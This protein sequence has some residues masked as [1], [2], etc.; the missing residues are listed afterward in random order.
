MIT[1]RSLLKPWAILAAAIGLALLALAACPGLAGADGIVIVDPPPDRPN[2]TWR[3][4]PLSIK[5]HQV[6]VTIKDQVA[7]TRVDQVF[8]ND[9]PFQVEGTYIFPLPEDAAISSFDMTVDGVKYEGQL[10]GREQAREIYEG[11]VR[12]QRD[13]ALLEYVGR[14]AFQARIF[15]IPPG[16]ERRIELS[17]SQVLKLD[18][19]LVHYRYPLNTEKYSAKPIGLVAVTVEIEDQSPIRTVY[20]P[21]HPVEV[22]HETERRATAS[23]EEKDVRPDRDFDLYYSLSTDAISVNLLSY[24]QAS[25]DGYF[26]L[27]VTPP[28]EAPAEAVAKDVVL[29]LDTSGSMDGDKIEQAQAAASF[30]LDNLGPQDRFNIINF[31]TFTHAFADAP[32]P[33]ER[34]EEGKAFVRDLLPEGSTNI[35]GALLE[36]L[37]G[38][39]PE[40]PTIL[41]F[42]TDGKPTANETDPERIVAN[43]SG[44]APKSV[45]LFAFGV[46]FDV[47]TLLLDELSSRTRG[48]SAYVHPHEAI[49]RAMADFYARVSAPVLVDVTMTTEGATLSDLY[50]HPLPDLFAGTQLMIA[51]RYRDG[52]DVRLV[53]AGNVNGQERRYTYSGLSLASRGGNENIARVWAQRKV[54]HLLSLIR[55]EGANPE[56]V[57]QVVDLSTRFG[58]MTPYTSFLVQ[59]PP[60]AQAAQPQVVRPAAEPTM[61][62]EAF[63]APAAAPTSAPAATAAPAAAP[64]RVVTQVV[65]KSVEKIVVVQTQVVEKAVQQWSAPEREGEAAVARVEAEQDL[66]QKAYAAG[67][68]AEGEVRQVGSKAFVQRGGAWVDTTYDAAKMS[69]ERIPFGEGRYFKLIDERPDIGPYL[70][71][72]QRV[73]VVLEGKAYAIGFGE[74]ESAPQPAAQTTPAVQATPTPGGAKGGGSPVCPGAA[75]AA[76]LVLLQVALPVARRVRGK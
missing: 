67:S 8:V 45:R 73:V 55:L 62:P 63:A 20:S 43:V 34:R 22:Q 6:D 59:E 70:A 76:M 11:I 41:I 17:Y 57:Q 60:A 16:A 51:G 47:D 69:I 48:V 3:D 39:D 15:P 75:G 32:Q 65:E 7:T 40:R 42:L 33:L 24:K 74:S 44:K 66:A 25:E 12:K 52:P 35:N 13:P 53:I 10:L 28:M 21:S 72:G 29:V 58:I 71:L 54:G 2:L 1:W 61:A 37:A 4:V 64:E 30:V 14:G 18:Q 49:D 31:G 5:Y 9:A 38:A 56:S 27:L 36:A 46:G 50:P 26:L 68:S 23:Y 19:G